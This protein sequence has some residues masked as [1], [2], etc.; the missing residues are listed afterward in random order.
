MKT[1][2]I[3]PIRVEPDLR[4][5]LDGVMREGESISQFFE[6]AVRTTIIQRVNQAEFVDRGIAAIELTKSTGSG[7]PAEV[8]IERLEAK[9]DRARQIQASKAGQ[10]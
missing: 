5:A 7:I 6:N 4:L 2:T 1:S 10:V 9:L 8:V 3:P